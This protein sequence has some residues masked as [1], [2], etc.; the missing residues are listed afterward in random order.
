MKSKAAINWGP[1]M[2]E[3][4]SRKVRRKYWEMMEIGSIFIIVAVIQV[5]RFVDIQL[6]GYLKYLH[7]YSYKL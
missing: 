2:E 5:T 1:R 3:W 4:L 7:F 6:N